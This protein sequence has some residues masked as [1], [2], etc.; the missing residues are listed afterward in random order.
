MNEEKETM[1]RDCC[2]GRRSRKW[3]ILIPLFIIAMVFIMGAVVMYLWNALMPNIFH[4]GTITYCQAILLLILSK[5]LF[6]GFRRGGGGWKRGGGRFS[7]GRE[8]KEK[9]MSMSEEERAKFKEEWK[10]RCC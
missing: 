3:W 6:G 1:D 2:S 8:W 4:L 10:N 7:R 9:W 5:I